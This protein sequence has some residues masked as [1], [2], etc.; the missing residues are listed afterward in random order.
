MP[1]ERGDLSLVEI[2][3]EVVNGQLGPL[4]VDLHQVVDGHTQ[5]QVGGLLLDAIWF[6]GGGVTRLL[7]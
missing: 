4:L 7:Q 2:E 5:H 1:Q 3:V 6:K